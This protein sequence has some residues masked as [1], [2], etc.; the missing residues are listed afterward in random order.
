VKKEV[1]GGTLH[2]NFEKFFC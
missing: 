2:Y 1:T